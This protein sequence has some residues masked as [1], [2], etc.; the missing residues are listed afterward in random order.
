MYVTKPNP[1]INLKNYFY[2]VLCDILPK[3]WVSHCKIRLCFWSFF[4]LLMKQMHGKLHI[5]HQSGYIQHIRPLSVRIIA[6]SNL[7]HFL[8]VIFEIPPSTYLNNP[9]GVTSVVTYTFSIGSFSGSPWS[10]YGTSVDWGV[11]CH[12]LDYCRC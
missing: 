11:H 5:F 10:R 9:M 3:R 2:K 12:H 8:G 7:A 1:F 4:H 6:F